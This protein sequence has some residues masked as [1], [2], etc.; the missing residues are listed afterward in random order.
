MRLQAENLGFCVDWSRGWG[1]QGFPGSLLIGTLKTEEG[2]SGKSGVT[3]A[4]FLK[5][6]L[7]GW[8]VLAPY[9]AV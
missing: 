5:G 1:A 9:L 7:C 2:E 6:A 4:R 3:V 8:G